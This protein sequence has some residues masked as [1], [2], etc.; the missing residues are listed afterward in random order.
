[1]ACSG[2]CTVTEYKYGTPKVGYIQ[3]LLPDAPS[4]PLN[5]PNAQAALDKTAQSM[6]ARSECCCVAGCWCKVNTVQNNVPQGQ[7]NDVAHVPWESDLTSIQAN[8][9]KDES[10]YTVFGLVDVQ[11]RIL[12]GHCKPRLIVMASADARPTQG[13]LG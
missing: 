3:G 5:D 10:G 1:M 11:S 4:L 9:K 2:K 6:P 13:E 12:D 8:F 7:P